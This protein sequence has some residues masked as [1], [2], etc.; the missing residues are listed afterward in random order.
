MRVMWVLI[1]L[2]IF[3]H[4]LRSKK[5]LKGSLQPKLKEASIW[6]FNVCNKVPTGR[7]CHM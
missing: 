5:N 4:R 2:K 6:S 3:M 7:I 1:H